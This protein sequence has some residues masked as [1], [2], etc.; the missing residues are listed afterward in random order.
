VKHDGLAWEIDVFTGPCKGLILAEVEL[1]CIDTLV[2]MP[3]WVG[4]E[5]TDDPQYRSSAIARA[6]HATLALSV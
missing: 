1:S 6:P 3:S 5:V 2:T 4:P